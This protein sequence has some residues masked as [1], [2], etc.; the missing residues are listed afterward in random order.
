MKVN[1]G[2]GIELDV[3]VAKLAA[4]LN[5]VEMTAGQRGNDVAPLLIETDNVL[6]HIFYIGLRNVLMDAH[7]SVTR[8][9]NPNDMADVSRAVA[10]KKLTALYAGEVRVAGT[11]EGDPVR[12][13]AIR[14]ATKAI[15][16]K[17]RA[18]GR[19]MKSVDPKALRAKAVELSANYLEQ[20]ATNVN[21]AKALATDL[22]DIEL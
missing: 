21:A 5:N 7:A 3:D 6:S 13:E 19:Q 1:I 2:K 17:L 20:A 9:T 11:R 10:E 15:T 16:I 4:R 14:L 12:A 18:A 8:E 22:G